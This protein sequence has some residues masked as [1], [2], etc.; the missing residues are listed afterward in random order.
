M[1]RPG[2]GP[3]SPLSTNSIDS[4]PSRY[5]GSSLG[6]T[7]NDIAYAGGPYG[8]ARPGQISPPGSQHPSSSTDMSRPSVSGSS[9]GRPPSSSSSVGRSSDGRL[10]FSQRPESGRSTFRPDNEDAL[11]RH[12]HVL[13]GY[14]ASSLRD[15][16]GNMRPN[17]ARDKLLRL[18]VTQFMEL[19]TDVYDEL[20]RRED[21][22]TGR[23][24]NVPKSLPPMQNFH[25]KRNQ[26]RQKLST[27]PVERF[28]QLATDVFYELERRIPRF[29]GADIDRPGSSSS[30]I[31]AMS[32]NGM[33]PPPAGTRGV[34]LPGPPA[35]PP[36][37]PIGAMPPNAPYQTFRPS[38]PGSG[39]PGPGTRPQTANSESSNY[40]RPLPKTFQ[41]NTIVPNKSTMVE[42]DDND[43][44]FDQ[45]GF[46]LDKSLSGAG[47][48]SNK[49]L[50]VSN[51]EDK[52][53]IA[54]QQAEI[55]ELREK[56][57]GLEGRVL[58]KEQE[59]ET[60]HGTLFDKEHELEKVKSTGQTREADLSTERNGWYDLREE[61]EQKHL[62]A[63]KLHDELRKELEQLQRSKSDD[64]QDLRAQHH[65]ELGE[66]RSQLSTAHRLDI[67]DVRAELGDV[68]E[69]NSGLQQQIQTH[70]AENEEL[71]QHLQTHQAGS[72]ELRQHLQIHQDEKDDLRQQLQTAHQSQQPIAN[73][74]DYEHRIELLQDELVLHEKL[75]NE[76]RDEA[77]LYLHE[78]RDL[79]SQNDLAIEQEEGLAARVAQLERENEQWRLRYAKVKAQNKSLRASTL[80]LGGIHSSAAGLVHR[81]GSLLS[82]SG[83]VRDLDVTRFQ[84]SI[85]DVL[86]AARQPD[87]EPLRE[88]VRNVAVCV[89]AI[90][91]AVGTTEGYPTPSPSPLGESERKSTE[92]VGRL[93]ARVTGTAKSLITAAKMHGASLGLS[94][95]VLLDAAASNLT[96]AVVELVKVVG[97]RSS[98]GEELRHS[99][100]ADDEALAVGADGDAHANSNGNMNG[101][102][103]GLTRGLSADPQH[104]H[105]HDSVSSFYD[106]RFSPSPNDERDLSPFPHHESSHRTVS[107]ME[108]RLH[109]PESAAEARELAPGAR[110][111]QTETPPPSK[112][113]PLNFVGRSG[114]KK[115]NGG[116][117]WF[118]GWG[119]KKGSV[120]EGSGNGTGTTV[121]GLGGGVGE[122]GVVAA[123]EEGRVSPEEVR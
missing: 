27:L 109:S 7:P 32:R 51:A 84:L 42:D 75:T 113:A 49:G 122:Q 30:H 91:S 72:E 121:G 87:T 61:L 53:R 62:D 123:P 94:P 9:L 90:T 1:N 57:D 110:D 55:V 60:L 117:G 82:D 31:R 80:G 8:V 11:Q 54:A 10:G 118:A 77:M 14:L 67:G 4:F 111:V 16:K 13:K 52:E 59:L 114:T 70:Q 119:G 69:R 20:L 107:P 103:N 86:H 56:I 99:F 88:S 66:M 74:S 76:V 92:S 28:R 5:G 101:N 81:N 102:I 100:I 120:D 45:D 12:Y 105:P 46:G 89:Q 71:R 22:R 29:G 6:G 37:S 104:S 43:E 50:N 106:D 44:E 26:A 15:E 24:Q 68:H 112:P 83:L 96:A 85:E 79:S 93:L 98:P 39:G 64:E 23:V 63:Q 36:R 78:M 108:V 38:S 35:R 3:L 33:R 18:S 2:P 40:G 73:A 48:P 58:D 34:P 19:S 115:G 97:I 95:V 41:S 65:R 25:P 47:A 116:T 21:E 17:K